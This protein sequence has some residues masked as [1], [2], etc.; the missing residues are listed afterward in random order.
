M[1]RRCSVLSAVTSIGTTGSRRVAHHGRVERGVLGGR[2]LVEPVA[3]GAL[4]VPALEQPIEEVLGRRVHDDAREVLAADEVHVV[5]AQVGRHRLVA[6]RAVRA[7]P[8]DDERRAA[9]QRVTRVQERL[10]VHPRRDEEVTVNAVAPRVA[11]ALPD[12]V[13]DVAQRGRLNVER[14]HEVV[15]AAHPEAGDDLGDRR[16]EV[17]HYA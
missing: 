12:C 2:D 4:S 1:S 13:V 14:R 5:D 9:A 3:A 17:G 8:L 15:G 7:L 11:Q 10:A 6:D 16:L